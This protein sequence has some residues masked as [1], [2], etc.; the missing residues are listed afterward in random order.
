M[1]ES[2]YNAKAIK[3]YEPMQKGD[4]IKTY[5]NI[6]ELREW[7]KFEPKISI[8]DGVKKFAKWYLDYYV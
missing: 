1:L 4:V 7:I 2:A 6:D 5:A 3:Q 8:Y